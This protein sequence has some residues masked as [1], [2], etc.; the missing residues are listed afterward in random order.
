[1]PRCPF[2]ASLFLVEGSPPQVNHDSPR[3]SRWGCICQYRP[4]S[5]CYQLD[6]RKTM[7]RSLERDPSTIVSDLVPPGLRG[8][9]SMIS[10]VH[11]YSPGMSLEALFLDFF[12]IEK[13]RFR[14][15]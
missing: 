7:Q 8:Y 12:I 15:Y 3:S 5:Y 2:S 11:N 4:F 10:V 13:L 1:M 14:T 6:L 9:G